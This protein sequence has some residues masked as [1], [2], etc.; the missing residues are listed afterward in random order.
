M[1]LN[2]STDDFVFDDWK[3]LAETNPQAFEEKRKRVIED[4]IGE[5]SEKHRSRLEGLQWRID[6]ER[7][8]S[9]N[10]F[11]ACV[12]ISNM[13][14]DSVYGERGLVSALKGDIK[15]R[16]DDSAKIIKIADAK[17]DAFVEQ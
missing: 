1:Q 13:M 4:M 2:D 5:A 9:S 11:S 8:R 15:R 6:I 3:T 7:K 17:S 10:P 14:L 16:E 12:R